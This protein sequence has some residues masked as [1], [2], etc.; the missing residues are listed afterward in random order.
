MK[1][2]SISN[3]SFSIKMFYQLQILVM[4]I[5]ANINETVLIDLLPII[6]KIEIIIQL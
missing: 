5:V 4:I 6:K 1:L 3:F 2:N